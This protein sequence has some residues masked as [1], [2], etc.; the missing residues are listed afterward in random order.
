MPFFWKNNQRSHGTNTLECMLDKSQASTNNKTISQASGPPC[1]HNIPPTDITNKVHSWDTSIKNIYSDDTKIFPIRSN[2]GNQY[3][4][5]L[6]N[7]DSNTILQALLR[8]NSDKHRLA[9]Y[10]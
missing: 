1:I 9:A 6:F 10:N 4:T 3:V 7:C 8:K 2:S 5:I